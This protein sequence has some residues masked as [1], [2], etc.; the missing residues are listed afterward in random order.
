MNATAYP[1]ALSIFLNFAWTVL[2]GAELWI[3]AYPLQ[4]LMLAIAIV[5]MF[6]WHLEKRPL[7]RTQKFLSIPFAMYAGWLTVAMIPFTSDLLNKSGWNYEP[8]SPV[9]WALIL[10][11]VACIIVWAA[12]RKLNHPFYLFPLAWALF[13]FVIRFEGALRLTAAILAGLLLIYFFL[14]L[15]RFYRPFTHSISQRNMVV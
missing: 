15:R 6:R 10:Y 14:Q 9:T 1:V 8:F 7:S 2:V 3:W 12:F 4:W 11:V 5:I 13:G